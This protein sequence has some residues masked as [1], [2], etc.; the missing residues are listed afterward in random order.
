MLSLFPL[1]SQFCS[2]NHPKSP[3]CTL[4]P[5]LFS[6]EMT[7]FMNDPITILV[8]DFRSAVWDNLFDICQIDLTVKFS[9]FFLY[10]QCIW[11]CSCPQIVFWGIRIGYMEM[12]F[13]ILLSKSFQS[14][15]MIFWYLSNPCNMAKTWSNQV[16]PL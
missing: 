11:N 14:W 15:K 1:T 12:I 7:L 10:N 2:K 8:F 4:P 13:L 16:V 6:C 3:F 9:I 5:A